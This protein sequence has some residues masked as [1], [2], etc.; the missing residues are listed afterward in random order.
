MNTRKPIRQGDVLIIPVAS[1]PRDA[2]PQP[3]THGKVIL[4]LGEA[5][6]HHHRFEFVDRQDGVKLFKS[7]N[8]DSYVKVPAPAD[9][10]HEEHS[11]ATVAKGNYL[12]ATQVEF[13][14]AELRTVQD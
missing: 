6:G 9:L 5:T 2:T 1:I 11:T 8:G 7:G 10:L 14:P 12:Q 13:T 3:S 4:A